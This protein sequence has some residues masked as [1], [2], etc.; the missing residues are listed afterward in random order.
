MENKEVILRRNITTYEEAVDYLFSIPRFTS[1]HTLEA[2]KEHLH[3][4]GDPDEQL[5]IIHVAGTNGKGSTC[6]YMRYILETAGYTTC[7]FTSPHLVDVRERFL[8]HGEMISKEH[9]MKMFHKVY[10]S[11][12]WDMLERGEG[13]HPTFF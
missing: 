11:L 6:A 10:D 13:Y 3:V 1:K 4:L 7:V 12:D 2:T 9:F 5:N 8:I